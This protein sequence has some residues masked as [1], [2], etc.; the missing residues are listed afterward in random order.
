MDGLSC[1]YENWEVQAG[2]RHEWMVSED[3]E[4]H[5]GL[6]HDIFVV[7]GAAIGL[8]YTALCIHF[9]N[10]QIFLEVVEALGNLDH[11]ASS[12]MVAEGKL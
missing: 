6:T 1:Q 3:W 11:G 8:E 12:Y 2:D 7:W 4:A 9:K 10:E 5:T